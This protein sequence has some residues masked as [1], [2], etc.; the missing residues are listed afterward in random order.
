MNISGVLF[1]DKKTI[2]I[3][4]QDL[5]LLKKSPDIFLINI[6]EIEN[7]N[8]EHLEIKDFKLGNEF[9]IVLLS[10]GNVYTCGINIRN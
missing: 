9:I 10:I 1:E 5:E 6:N 4:G 8:N 2:A 3:F 7:E